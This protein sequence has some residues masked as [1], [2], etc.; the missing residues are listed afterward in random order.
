[1]GDNLK[2]FRAGE[3]P[4]ALAGEEDEAQDHEGYAESSEDEQAG[5]VD[6]PVI[7]RHPG[8]H[9]RQE[10]PEERRYQQ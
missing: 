4:G 10:E 7:P 3:R 8:E 9:D 2:A 5:G 1:M 6:D